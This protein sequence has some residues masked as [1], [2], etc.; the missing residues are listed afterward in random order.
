MTRSHGFT[1][2]ELVFVISII[3]LLA[4]VAMPA[5]TDYLTRAMTSEG[6]QLASP[7]QQKVADYYA[8]HGDFP[9][10]NAALALPAAASTGAYVMSLRV[11]QGHILITYGHHAAAA[12]Q[13]KTLR[14]SPHVAAASF[15][16][17]TWQ[18]SSDGVDRAY[19]PTTC[20]ESL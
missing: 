15:L 6:L 5:Y 4:A 11:E 13:G 18:C 20:R 9:A 7:V 17:L 2:I 14:I 19:L 12:L 1:L 8:W 3:S 10:D 16:S